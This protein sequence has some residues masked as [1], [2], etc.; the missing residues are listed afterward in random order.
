MLRATNWHNAITYSPFLKSPIMF[1]ELVIDII[2]SR[3]K[4]NW[5]AI[6]AFNISFIPDRSLMSW[7]LATMNVGR[8]AM[9]LVRRTRF[10]RAH[11]KSRKPYI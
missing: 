2:G 9:V 8:I 4:G 10:H 7:N 11:L 1:S 3:A 6:K 5:R